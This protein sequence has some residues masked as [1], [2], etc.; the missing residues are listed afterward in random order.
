MYSAEVT[1]EGQKKMSFH[2]NIHFFGWKARAGKERQG[3]QT[4]LP[5][6][7]EPEPSLFRQFADDSDEGTIFIFQPLVV[8]FQFC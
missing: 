4:S 6:L 5:S 7:L 2:Q 8:R 1:E 3:Q